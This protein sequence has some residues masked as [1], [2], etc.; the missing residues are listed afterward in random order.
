MDL[1]QISRPTQGD[2]EE[3]QSFEL[4]NRDYFARCSQSEPFLHLERAD[5]DESVLATDEWMG[6]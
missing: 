5:L 3:L 6:R 1:I 4:V 2:A